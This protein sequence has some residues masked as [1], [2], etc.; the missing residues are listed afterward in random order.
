MMTHVL[1]FINKRFYTILSGNE[2]LPFCSSYCPPSQLISTLSITIGNHQ[3]SNDGHHHD[4]RDIER[5]SCSLLHSKSD[6]LWKLGLIR[7]VEKDSQV[8]A[9]GLISLMMNHCKH[10]H[11][12]QLYQTEEGNELDYDSILSNHYMMSCNSSRSR[13]NITSRSN[14]SLCASMNQQDRMIDANRLVQDAAFIFLQKF[15]QQEL[16][17]RSNLKRVHFELYHSIRMNHKKCT[18]PL[19]HRQHDSDDDVLLGKEIKLF[20]DQEKEKQ[21]LKKI[22]PK[23]WFECQFQT[24]HEEGELIDVVLNDICDMDAYPTI[25]YTTQMYES[26]TTTLSTSSASSSSSSLEGTIACIAQ[27]QRCLMYEDGTAH[28]LVVPKSYVQIEHVFPSKGP[29]NSDISDVCHDNAQILKFSRE[30]CRRMTA[31]KNSRG[32]V[33]RMIASYWTFI[34]MILYALLRNIQD[35]SVKTRQFVVNKMIN[36][37]KSMHY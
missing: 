36:V 2:N 32:N 37:Q 4:H 9:R 30:K 3:D 11:H 17:C 10:Q 8:W 28:V 19:L 18:L 6:Y 24:L 16:D 12:H 31:E 29:T 35:K 22:L 20:L 23:F 27:L 5:D 34:I 26:F 15:Q 33:W 13:N 14:P 21:L 25:I 1:P 7:L